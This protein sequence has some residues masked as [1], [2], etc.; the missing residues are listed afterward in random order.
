MATSTVATLRSNLATQITS[1]LTTD[2]ITGVQVNEFPP[3]DDMPSSDALFLGTIRVTQINHTF[4]GSREEE[5]TAEGFIWVVAPGAG[6][7]NAAVAEDRAVAI[8]ASV[9][10]E[11]RADPTVN[12]AV[13][14]S[15]VDGFD[16]DPM[17]HERGRATLLK[18]EIG[19]VAHI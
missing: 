9:E 2:G 3:G 19:A 16:S 11:L 6:D 10:N 18:F 13:F 12:G 14:D 5:L 4:G 15:E 17:I 7:T 8:F 1:R